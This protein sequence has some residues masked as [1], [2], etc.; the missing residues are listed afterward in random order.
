MKVLKS[1]VSWRRGPCGWQGMGKMQDARWPI[2]QIARLREIH[3]NTKLLFYKVF[4]RNLMLAQ[5][6]H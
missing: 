3:K 6:L 2:L 4:I 5:S 1:F